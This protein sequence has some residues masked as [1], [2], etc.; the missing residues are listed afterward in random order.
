MFFQFLWCLCL[1][2]DW[3]IFHTFCAASFFV[4]VWNEPSRLQTEGSW[5]FSVF[6][7]MK[8]NKL[9]INICLCK[10]KVHIKVANPRL[11]RFIILFKAVRVLQSSASVCRMLHISVVV[12]M[13]CLWTLKFISS[14]SSSKQDEEIIHIDHF[15]SSCISR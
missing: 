15:L 3:F 4:G 13:N 5:N 9:L 2:I 1:L 10:V 8:N 11:N 7:I 6:N 12:V 14:S